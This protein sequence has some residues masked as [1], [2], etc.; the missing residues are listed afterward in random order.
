MT[1]TMSASQKNNHQFSIVAMNS[2]NIFNRK[3]MGLDTRVWRT[4][5][6]V[7][8]V[9]TGILGYKFLDKDA[10]IPFKIDTGKNAHADSFYFIRENIKFFASV[11][12]ENVSWDFK[13]NSTSTSHGRVVTHSF[14]NEGQY[15]VT[16]IVNA[17]C[18]ETRLITVKNRPKPGFVNEPLGREII[19]P[20]A[21]YAGQE[22]E[23]ISPALADSIYEWEVLYHP[24]IRTQ[25]GEK[26]KF[27]F[28]KGGTFTIL[29]TLDGNRIKSYT[30]R[31][32]VEDLNIQKPKMPEDVPF[33]V[34]K[35]LPDDGN[36]PE[37]PEVIEP[38]KVN[39]PVVEDPKVPNTKALADDTFKGYLQ[40]LVESEM[41]ESE[42]YKYLC[43]GGSTAVV[44]NGDRNSKTFNWLC[45]DIKG[46]KARPK[47]YKR[48]KFISIE[49]IRLHRDETGCVIK[50]EVEY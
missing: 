16:A 7:I 12:T 48:K 6:F 3:I 39:D 26:A 42:F 15:Y 37:K 11:S 38:A 10:C 23:Y 50:I 13:D 29:L 33:L 31:V 18:E 30:R 24:E 1:N 4:M 14:Q 19:G 8:I 47:F 9:S 20:S 46:K 21:T 44:V 45:Q 2:Y 36:V 35:K 5:F 34:R 40:K 28:D 27:K 25:N 22:E 32:I 41:T 17:G 43:G 49:S